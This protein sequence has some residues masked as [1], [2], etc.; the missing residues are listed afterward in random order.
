ML[1]VL[2]FS[3]VT[4]DR[5]SPLRGSV[6]QYDAAVT[7]DLTTVTS[8]VADVFVSPGVTTGTGNINLQPTSLFAVNHVTP[9]VGSAIVAPVNVPPFSAPVGVVHAPGRVD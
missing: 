1:L 6:S 4:D 9:S 8:T 5:V 2:F 3:G 7:F